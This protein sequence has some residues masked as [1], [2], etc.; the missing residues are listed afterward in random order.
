MGGKKDMEI[1]TARIETDLPAIAR[2]VNTFETYPVTVEQLYTWFQRDS[3]P[4][5]AALRLVAVDEKDVVAGYGMIVHAASAPAY[6]FYVWVGVDPA[7]R[8]RKIGSALWDAALAYLKGQGATRLASEV[9]DYDPLGLA[10]AERR[11]FTIYQRLFDSILDLASFDETP[12]LPDLAALAAQG[13]RFCALADFTDTPETRRKLYDLNAANVLDIPGVVNLPWSF[14]EF[15]EMMRADWF[16]AEGQLLA[17]DG[18]TWV[19]LAAVRLIPESQEAYNEHTGVL[20]A[21]RGR[22]IAQ[23]LKIL[24]ARYAR[25]HGALKLRTDNNS[26]NKPIL[27]INRKLGYQP[28]PGKY[29][30]VRWLE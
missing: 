21:Y 20:R 5:Y 23:A 8:C 6:H 26:D 18:E 4:G 11:G 19:G 25:Q 24:A 7:F 1:R 30:L 3:A 12:Y 2:L 13:I 22:K 9:L 16:R 15:E 28:Q 14:P 17:V 27:A 29:T 10:F